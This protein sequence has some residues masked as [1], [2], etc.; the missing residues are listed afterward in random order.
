[1]ARRPTLTPAEEHANLVGEFQRIKDR[2]SE[3]VRKRAVRVVL[4]PS[5]IRVFE[6]KSTDDIRPVLEAV[7]I[8]ELLEIKKESEFRDWFNKH[9]EK[10]K[11]AVSVKNSSNPRIGEGYIL[12]HCTKVLTLYLREI[13]LNSR[14]FDDVETN[15][16]Q[17]LLY[18]PIDS[19]NIDRLEDLGCSLPFNAIK[20]IDTK[21]KFYHVQDALGRAAAQVGIPRIWFDDNW[22]DRQ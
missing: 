13:V 22:G 9:L 16:I 14:Y 18:A 6:K 1:M 7:P 5:V 21:E 8:D 11:E 17:Y 19:I 10:V 3:A 20:E 4:G 15:R 2:H 12:G